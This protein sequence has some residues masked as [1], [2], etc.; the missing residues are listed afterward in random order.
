M[1]VLRRRP[2]RRRLRREDVR[3][4]RRSPAAKRRHTH[5]ENGLTPPPRF[6]VF[7]SPDLLAERSPPSARLHVPGISHL[8][9]VPF[10]KLREPAGRSV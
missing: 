5:P 2:R 9:L 8:L 4:L 7:F 1:V 10:L 6:F 3:Y